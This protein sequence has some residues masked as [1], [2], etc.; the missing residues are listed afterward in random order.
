ME[1][2][3]AVQPA[4]LPVSILKVSSSLQLG[5][6]CNL[7]CLLLLV[8]NQAPSQ[9]HHKDA[10][11]RHCCKLKQRCRSTRTSL[12]CP[13]HG[14]SNTCRVSE[15]GH[16]AQ[17]EVQMAIKTR[18]QLLSAFMPCR[19]SRGASCETLPPMSLIGP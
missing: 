1:I 7:F 4:A 5:A 19:A 12:A 6:D 3:S 8:L 2:A 13:M 18:L 14:L 16:Q 15:H 17:A 9:P 11:H 10:S